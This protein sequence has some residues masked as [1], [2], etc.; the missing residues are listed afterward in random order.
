MV[1]EPDRRA[2]R[3]FISYS[4]D[5]AE[6]ANQVLTLSNR[7]RREGV[8]CGIDQYEESPP[9]GWPQWMIEQIEGAAFVLLVCTETY[10]RRFSGKEAGNKGKGARWEGAI[11]TLQLYEDGFTNTR[12][13]PVL[14]S[15]G[16]PST[17]PLVLRGTT[18]YDLSNDRGYQRLY[19]RLTGQSNKTIEP[20]VYMPP[21]PAFEK[22]QDFFQPWNVPHPHNPFFTGREKVISELRAALAHNGSVALLEP[23]AISGMGGIGKTQIAVEY[24]YRFR[25]DYS[26]VFWIRA[27]TR[28]SFFADCAEVADLL[29]LS[30]ANS[31]K[32]EA[33]VS[34]T[35][36]WL[37]DNGG[38]LLVLDSADDLELIKDLLP[39]SP[40]GHVLITSRAQVFD[41]LGI[42]KPIEVDEMT[43]EEALEF[44]LVRTG[45]DGVEITDKEA[46]KKLVAELGYLPLALEQA[47]AF[48]SSTKT[49]FKDY[50]A[51]FQNRRL[52]LL[53]KSKPVVGNYPESVMTTWAM[54]FQ[55]VEHT[56]SAAADLLRFSAFLHPDAIPLDL[57]AAG[58]IDLGPA[59][60]IAL[61]NAHS[62]PVVINEVLEPLTRFSLIRHDIASHSY[63][64]H[65]LVQE[66]TQSAM[67]A[68]VRRLWAERTVRALSRACAPPEYDSEVMWIP[69]YRY[70]TQALTV[71]QLIT[72]W[73]FEFEPAAVLLDT[74][75]N[76]LLEL[77]QLSEAEQF[78]R[79]SLSLKQKYFGETHQS[80]AV[81]F[82]LLAQLCGNQ[83]R[84]SEAESL[85]KRAIRTLEDSRGPNHPSVASAL[86]DLAQFYRVEKSFDKAEAT[87]KHAVAIYEGADS[88]SLGLSRTLNNF[89]FLYMHRGKR[90]EAKRLLERALDIREQ[91]LG[92]GHAGLESTLTNLADINLSQGD[93][94]QAQQLYQRTLAIL[95]DARG[96]EHPHVAIC[97]DNLAAVYYKQGNLIQAESLVVRA[98]SIFVK[99]PHHPDA[100]ICFSTL[101]NIYAAQ[102]KF[103]EAED[104]YKRAA[105]LA[106]KRSK[107]APLMAAQIA[108]DYSILLLRTHRFLKG[109]RTAGRAQAIRNRYIWRTGTS[110]DRIHIVKR[111]M[112]GVLILAL[113]I[114]LT[115]RL[116]MY[117]LK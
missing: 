49:R 48:L 2:P 9:Q 79:S 99:H 109:L 60:S 106:G 76:A 29:N 97:L 68:D 57:I 116:I 24:A 42:V 111:W 110:F 86:T 53:N 55:E 61:S 112:E 117:L 17:I 101:A 84:M 4:H 39:L 22:K 31:P 75:G 62:D 50:F 104:L 15:G 77:Y 35:K 59:I 83:G 1:T 66:V 16:T 113:V 6:H 85:L 52:E 81:S 64:V 33:N 44:I 94:F 14:L 71:A 27:D 89:A 5:S 12:F 90:A 74:I 25:R 67:G 11:V 43:P 58:A 70:I 36:N 105:E 41:L 8:D 88:N 63:R 47:G 69:D 80:L 115:Y 91:I 78:L 100:P 65:R 23:Q 102:G 40:Q 18:Y 34:A 56:S 114:W 7:L 45:R 30:E 73:D 92:P 107:P 13:I 96:P 38:W 19:R 93:L 10:S 3:V 108:S 26:A 46:A 21:M 54:N 103:L 32:P 87:Y 95:E 51:A 98:S 20:I 28:L 37:Q 72:E 82:V